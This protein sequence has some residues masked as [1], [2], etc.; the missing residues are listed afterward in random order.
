MTK[1]LRHNA[2]FVYLAFVITGLT[3]V[4]PQRFFDTAALP[5][6]HAWLAATLLL[7]SV[8]SLYGVRLAQR[9]GFWHRPLQGG[10][11]VVAGLTA[12]LFVGLEVTALWLFVASQVL[13]RMLANYATQEL[14]R[15]SVMLAPGVERAGNDR[16]GMALRFLG[17]L[18]GPLWF[19]LFVGTRTWMA[20]G[21]GLLALLAC[22]SVLGLARVPVA[23]HAES[24]SASPL[25]LR[26]RLLAAGVM[27]AYGAYYLLAS[28]VVFV[29][30]DLHHYPEPYAFGGALVATVYGAAVLTSIASAPMTRGGI[31]LPWMLLAPF[32]MTLAAC[33]LHSTA[34]AHAPVAVGGAALLGVA[35]AF[36]L[37][38][39]RNHVTRQVEAGNLGWLA[40]FNNLGNTSA[41][42]GFSAMF[43]VVTLARSLKVD[44][45]SALIVGLCGLA[46]CA[47]LL[48][49]PM[50]VG[51]RSRP[52]PVR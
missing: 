25:N 28:N 24:P 52:Q 12:V 14:D 4:V 5:N 18:L 47:F 23:L 43:A 36:F 26:E 35:F 49:W 38:A 13:A 37:L 6:K 1:L 51:G 50:I 29:L 21:V 48:S 2:A 8:A 9:F 22:V 7:G 16:A 27:C 17:M 11:S 41:L 46:A 20:F 39:I 44:Y 19:G 31:S 42:V 34:A 33:C 10:L 3:S 15:R 45:S 30:R 40:I 32:T